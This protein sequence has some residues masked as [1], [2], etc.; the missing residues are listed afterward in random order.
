[1]YC[2]ECGTKCPDDDKYC[3]ECAAELIDNQ[4]FGNLNTFGGL[5]LNSEPMKDTAQKAVFTLK[6]Y[7][8]I[9]GKFLN[10]KRGVSYAAVGVLVVI[11]FCAILSST[12]FSA[13]A[14]AKRYF[15]AVIEA[16]AQKAYSCLDIIETPFTGYDVFEEYWEDTHKNADIFNYRIE[17]V[18][19]QKERLKTNKKN[20][21]LETEFNVSYFLRGSNSK[22]NLQISVVR[23]A[24]NIFL[25]FPNYKVLP[26][27]LVTDFEL[28][29]PA[30]TTIRFNGIEL[31]QVSSSADQPRFRIDYAFLRPYEAE[32]RNSLSETT[33][34]AFFPRSSDAEHLNFLSYSD[35]VQSNVFT[36]AKQQNEK[37]VKAAIDG[38]MFP[39][40]VLVDQDS[41]YDVDYYFSRYSADFQSNYDYRNV[42]S[43]VITNVYDESNI[44]YIS[45]DK[46]TY[47]CNLGITY[48]YKYEK[49]QNNKNVI[50]EKTD[51]ANARLTYAYEDNQWQ[52]TS[53]RYDY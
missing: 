23:G 27:F 4:N 5:S 41:Y 32:I 34:F 10:E 50:E 35:E 18:S 14:V 45:P 52:L 42:V 38:R 1:M 43:Y 40:D 17:N 25:V 47:E 12:I 31:E 28:I 3:Q 46:I 16:D 15:K 26:D 9:I 2:P 29:A 7:L 19:K 24:K 53:L 51:T 8:K 6:K 37:I 39:D 11:V 22:R 20:K 44:Q 21:E 48:S 36:L 49:R 13:Q 33:A 30:G